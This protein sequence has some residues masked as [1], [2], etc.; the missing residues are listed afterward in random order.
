MESL[1]LRQ[2]V[3]D[4]LRQV[5]G[6]QNSRFSEVEEVVYLRWVNACL[7][8]ELRHSQAGQAA[9]KLSRTRSPRSQVPHVETSATPLSTATGL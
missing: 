8:F 3:A 4:L 5:E 1:V 9:S 2:R 7:R 6:L